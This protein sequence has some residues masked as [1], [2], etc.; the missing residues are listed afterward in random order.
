MEPSR[1]FRSWRRFKGNLRLLEAATKRRKA[2]WYSMTST[3]TAMAF[4][5]DKNR[6]FKNRPNAAKI[7]VWRWFI[8]AWC[9]VKC[10]EHELSLMMRLFNDW[11]W[12]QSPAFWEMIT[13]FNATSSKIWNLYIFFPKNYRQ[14]LEGIKIHCSATRALLSS[15]CTILHPPY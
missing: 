7:I 9:S 14:N 1:H 2:C 6:K 4:C 3:K 8:F 11:C 12:R 13:L 5:C 15:N 10:S